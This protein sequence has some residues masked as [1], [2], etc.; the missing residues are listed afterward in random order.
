M[1]NPNPVFDIKWIPGSTNLF[2][3]AHGDGSLVVYDKE[4]EDVAFVPESSDVSPITYDKPRMQ[5]YKSVQSQNQKANPVA[6][7]RL[8]K[9]RINSLAF[10]PDG[11]YLAAGTEGG[12]LYVIDHH[13][14]R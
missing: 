7:W 11:K 14:E 4:K 13:K 6:Y 9:Q 2:I 1:I 3:A 10:S 12:R 8:S 5:L